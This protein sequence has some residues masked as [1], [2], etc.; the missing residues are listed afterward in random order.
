MRRARRR[1]A[2]RR[3]AR[4]RLGQRLQAAEEP[5]Q[6][7]SGSYEPGGWVQHLPEEVLLAPTGT[8]R[9]HRPR[10]RGTT[11][12]LSY[13][14]NRCVE[15]TALPPPAAPVCREATGGE[16]AFRARS[17][18][19][20]VALGTVEGLTSWKRVDPGWQ[21]GGETR[22]GT[23]FGPFY[24]RGRKQRTVTPFGELEVDSTLGCSTRPASGLRPGFAA[25][26]KTVQL[27]VANQGGSPPAFNAQISFTSQSKERTAVV[28]VDPETTPT[29]S[30]P[31]P[32]T[33]L[34]ANVAETGPADLSP[35]HRRPHQATR[36][37][38]STRLHEVCRRR[39]RRRRR[40]RLKWVAKPTAASKGDF[41]RRSVKKFF[42]STRRRRSKLSRTDYST[43]FL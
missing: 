36:E 20:G 30:P 32:S 4:G 13:S 37:F 33:A 7:S 2:R 29:A 24:V 26:T 27:V 10:L 39:R 19:R 1:R 28:A 5:C 15:D 23:K 31:P 35:P 17:R 25:F 16:I 8:K 42:D 21:D 14:Y 22:L 38:P 18:R 11:E 9:R 6:R 43:S 41:S 34:N 40:Q 3:W 12:V